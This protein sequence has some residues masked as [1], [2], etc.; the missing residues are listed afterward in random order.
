MS[1]SATEV[2][3]RELGRLALPIAFTQAGIALMNVV[4]AAVVGRLGATPLAAVG[5][6]NG[7][8][9]SVAIIGIGVMLG[10]DPLMSQAFGAGDRL[11]AKDL[12]WQGVWLSLAVAVVLS[13][14]LTFAPL[15]LRTSGVDGRVADDA[16]GFLW[17]RLPG[18]VP[19]FLYIG[20]RSYLQA[21][22]VVRPLMVSAV[23]GNVFNFLGDLLLVFGGANLPSWS[24]PLR[25]VPSLGAA[26]AGLSTTLCSLFQ[27]GIVACA[28]HLMGGP[29]P[30]RR[31]PRRSDLGLSSRLGIPIGLQMGAEVGIFALV[32]LLAGRLE[33]QSL[34][35]H[36]IALSLA[37]FTFCAAVGIG[38]AGSVRVGWAVGA[39]DR[40]AARRS[41]LLA[42]A[43]GAGFMCACA[44]VFWVVPR[45][46]VGALSDR[47]EVIAVAVPLIGV[48][49]VFQISDGLQAVG[50]GI[51]RGAG[52]TRYPFVANLVG[53]YLVGLPVAIL[54]GLFLRQG[55]VGLWWGL[56]AG[57]TAV[58]IGL[59]LRFWKLSSRPIP[60]VESIAHLR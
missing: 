48:A 6:G 24:G 25:A 20:V 19:T 47:A 21:A 8:F 34:A 17:M 45:P 31:R 27:L 49:A 60:R 53:H 54:L 46:L 14:P 22:G 3:L 57:L 39:G 15:L 56:C 35:A 30:R 10:L 18:L 7:L 4:D 59:F 1:T 29:S 41:G 37:S 9:F 52:D 16:V 36:T 13:I 5:L 44:C 42:L 43:A 11:R 51:L 58:A 50:A 23:A 2:E 32:A 28:V 12:L 55:V 33:P 40:G 38:S 26:G